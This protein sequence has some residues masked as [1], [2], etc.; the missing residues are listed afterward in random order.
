M[1]TKFAGSMCVAAWLIC[2]FMAQ[3]GD[4][5]IEDAWELFHHA[6]YAESAAL[7]N[8]LL[9]KTPDDSQRAPAIL[10]LTSLNFDHLAS[11]SGLAEDELKAKSAAETIVK[12]YPTSPFAAEAYFYLGEIYSGHVPVK[13]ETD[14]GK[15][16]GMF[17]KAVEKAEK[18]WVK[19]ESYKGI[20]RCKAQPLGDAAQKLYDLREYELA[21]P[22]FEKV[23]DRYPKSGSAQYAQMMVG[24]CREGMGKLAEAIAAYEEY[25]RSYK[26][27]AGDTLF[28]YYASALDIAGRGK[29]AEKY[30]GKVIG[31]PASRPWAAESAKVKLAR[32]KEGARTE[33]GE[34]SLD[35]PVTLSVKDVPI[36]EFLDQ[37]SE[38]ARV[39]FILREGSEKGRVTAEYSGL[40]ARDVLTQVL[41]A[42]N[43]ALH[44]VGNSGTYAILPAGQA[45]VSDPGAG[46]RDPKLDKRVSLRFRNV[47]LSVFLDAV[48]TQTGLKFGIA[49]DI[50]QMKTTAF[51]ENL[52][53]RNALAMISMIKDLTYKKNTKT[54]AYD[55]TLAK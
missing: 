39:N 48:S 27:F 50:S 20:E 52:P 17:A 23:I 29:E 33:K 12:D 31:D 14:C 2:P 21:L 55:F 37:V 5:T 45:V 49:D 22:V 46:I 38:Q 10:L 54:G 26:P 4:K 53:A 41:S 7:C 13:I 35:T 44:P 34:S 1:K 8:K 25:L 9:A 42:Q 11:R 36:T 43:L 6:Q 28:Y 16:V 18:Q 47:P 32:L 30:Y 51:F 24:L 40:A 15:A 19:D 3:A